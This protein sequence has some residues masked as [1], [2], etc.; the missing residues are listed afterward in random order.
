MSKENAEICFWIGRNRKMLK[1]I[2]LSLFVFSVFFGCADRQQPIMTT[3]VPAEVPEVR[4][5]YENVP[6][7][8]SNLL[9][10]GLYRMQVVGREVINAKITTVATVDLMFDESA[11]PEP[12][13]VLINLTRNPWWETEDGKEVLKVDY[14]NVKFL[15]RGKTEGA[16]VFPTV[17]VKITE[18]VSV[19]D[20]SKSFFYKGELIANITYPDRPFEY[21]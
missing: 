12:I 19:D 20:F 15:P 11:E 14:S 2:V 3:E 4:S 1:Q 10:P 8:T 21:E 9:D 18:F 17:V 6:F 7:I 5:E 13:R 16:P